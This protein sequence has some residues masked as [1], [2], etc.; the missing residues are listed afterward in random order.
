MSQNNMV[1]NSEQKTVLITGGLSDIGRATA[2]G[3]AKAGYCV[4][5]N[6]RHNEE[7]ARAFAEWLVR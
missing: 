3:F 5:L 4:A 2:T 6:Y 1:S 7:P